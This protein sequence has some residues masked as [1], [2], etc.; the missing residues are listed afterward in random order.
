MNSF[1]HHQFESRGVLP[2][3]ATT[4]IAFS[5]YGRMHTESRAQQF[6]W[7]P[8]FANDAKQLQQVLLRR[9]WRFLHS[10]APMPE[11]IDRVKLNQTAT[12]K[13]LKGHEIA[14]DA[15]VIQHRMHAHH[16]M[17]VRRA[18]GYL[19]LQAAIA[20]RAWRLGQNSPTVA[21]SVGMTSWAVRAVL[22]RLRH[23]ARELGYDT[24]RASHSAGKPRAKKNRAIRGA[25]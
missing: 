16:K 4:G 24:G 11:N 19:E 20:Y 15:A 1:D 18:G 5:D 23:C 6:A 8:P 3:S 13:A 25:A 10:D 9:A 22:D 12:A 21:E 17:A 7:V 14:T 2:V